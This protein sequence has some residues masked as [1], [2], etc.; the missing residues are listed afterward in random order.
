M[1]LK[2]GKVLISKVF[3][4]GDDEVIHL[5]DEEIKA[6]LEKGAIIRVIDSGVTWCV[7]VIFTKYESNVLSC[8]FG[9]DYY[10]ELD[11]SSKTLGV[12]TN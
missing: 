4:L 3:G 7:D 11:L 2:G 12:L 6:I 8:E 5:S 1:R 9:V 10:I